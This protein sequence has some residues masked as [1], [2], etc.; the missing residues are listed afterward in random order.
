[1]ASHRIE[2]VLVARTV[3]EKSKKYGTKVCSVFYS[4]F[5]KSLIRVYPLPVMSNI[6]AWDRVAL[7][8]EN[9]P[10]DS[11]RESYKLVRDD[12]HSIEFIAKDSRC[13]VIEKMRK[14]SI[15]SIEVANKARL[16]LAFTRASECVVRFKKKEGRIGDS[17]LGLFEDGNDELFATAS[18]YARCPYLDFTDG[19]GRRRS[20]QIREWG[21]F[22]LLRRGK[23]PD[24]SKNDWPNW[25]GKNTDLIVGNMN[26]HR[27]VW[28]VIHGIKSFEKLP[29]LEIGLNSNLELAS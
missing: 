1:M 13:V 25:I 28:M 4:D 18:D 2:A 20:L 21:C 8:I 16:S 22:E 10:H 12:P 26:S 17:Q 3:P 27:N 11:R 19:D 9:N 29:L 5:H 23:I 15:Q 14:T 24:L 6:K 7:H